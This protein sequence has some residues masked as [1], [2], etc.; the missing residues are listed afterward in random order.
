[1]GDGSQTDPPLILV[2]EILTHSSGLFAWEGSVPVCA[3]FGSNDATGDSP[4]FTKRRRGAAEGFRWSSYRSRRSF[5]GVAREV[6]EEVAP[7]TMAA[8]S[9]WAIRLPEPVRWNALFLE[10]LLPPSAPPGIRTQNL[11]IKSPLL[12]H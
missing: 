7:A 12:C 5:T 9:R 6:A 3:K 10:N 1:M 4:V 2:A 11:R 8:S